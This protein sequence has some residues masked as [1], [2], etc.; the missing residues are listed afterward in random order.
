MT[1]LGRGDG[2]DSDNPDLAWGRA[3]CATAREGSSGRAAQAG[4]RVAQVGPH[5]RSAG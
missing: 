1:S 4:I 2:T 5:R 3:C